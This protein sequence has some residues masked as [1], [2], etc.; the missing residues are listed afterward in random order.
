MHLVDEKDAVPIR[1]H[2]EL[3][4]YFSSAGKPVERWRVGTEHELVGV[5][6]SPPSA[7]GT[8]PTYDGASGIGALFA[9]FAARGGTPVLEG[10]HTIA[11]QRGDDQLTIEPGGQFELASRPVTD[12][13]EFA[14]ELAEYVLALGEASRELGL[15]WLSTGLRPFGGRGDVPWMPKDR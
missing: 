13:Q 15:A 7:A 10:G 14:V 6:T 1:S 2:D 5:V 3:L 12:D 8:P 4:A 9:W 11:L